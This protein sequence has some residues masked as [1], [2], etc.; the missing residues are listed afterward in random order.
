MNNETVLLSQQWHQSQSSLCCTHHLFDIWQEEPMLAMSQEYSEIKWGCRKLLHLT[1]FSTAESSWTS[2]AQ[3]DCK[4]KIKSTS[5]KQN[6]QISFYFNICST[7]QRKTI[8]FG[9]SK[10]CYYY[11]IYLD[12][13]Y[14]YK[15]TVTYK[16]T[17]CTPVP[18]DSESV[19]VSCY[20]TLFVNIHQSVVLAVLVGFQMAAAI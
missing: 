11:N 14:I 13:L 17:Y 12:H 19:T 18:C 6:P 20:S 4:S 10:V 2:L 9:L 5:L 1:V 7:C 8:H 3:E 16:Q 15:L